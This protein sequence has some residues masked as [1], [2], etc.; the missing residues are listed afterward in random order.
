[1][2][3]K[4]AKFIVLE[5]FPLYMVLDKAICQTDSSGYVDS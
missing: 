5:I 1:M 4:T 2:S 3:S